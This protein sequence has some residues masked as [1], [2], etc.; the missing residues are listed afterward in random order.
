M[1]I[2]NIVMVI[3]STSEVHSHKAVVTKH[4][5]DSGHS[6]HYENGCI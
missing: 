3:G 2:F 6:L 4:I 5:L 1:I